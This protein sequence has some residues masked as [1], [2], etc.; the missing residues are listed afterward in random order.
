M[1]ARYKTVKFVNL[2]LFLL[3]LNHNKQLDN[4]VN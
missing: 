1:M 2:D 3:F 4:M